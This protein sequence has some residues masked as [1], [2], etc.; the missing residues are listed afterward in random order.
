MFIHGSWIKCTP[1]HR[2]SCTFCNSQSTRVGAA[3]RRVF[4][5]ITDPH[6]EYV[7]TTGSSHRLCSTLHKLATYMSPPP[8]YGESRA[9]QMYAV[10]HA[11][12]SRFH[13]HIYHCANVGVVCKAEVQAGGPARRIRHRQAVG[14]L[15]LTPPIPCRSLLQRYWTHAWVPASPKLMTAL[16]PQHNVVSISARRTR[17]PPCSMASSTSLMV[18]GVS[19]CTGARSSSQGDSAAC[20]H[21]WTQKVDH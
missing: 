17:G 18:P 5:D 14:F 6:P 2:T 16:H 1:A 8:V 10:N 21:V 13:R 4:H 12:G 20:Q 7:S 9:M 19:T 15:L 11:W 3:A